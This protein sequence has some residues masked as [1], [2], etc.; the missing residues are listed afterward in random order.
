[1]PPLSDGYWYHNPLV[2]CPVLAHPPRA[3]LQEPG[4]CRKEVEAVTVLGVMA[5]VGLKKGKEAS[6]LRFHQIGTNLGGSAL[7]EYEIAR[8]GISCRQLR[9]ESEGPLSFLVCWNCSL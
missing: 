9:D 5:F 8:N 7:A 3:L 1:M 4:Y 2:C 6:T